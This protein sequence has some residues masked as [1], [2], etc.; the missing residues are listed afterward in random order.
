M[1]L[2]V[3]CGAL[4]FQTLIANHSPILVNPVTILLSLIDLVSRHI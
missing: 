1:F 2:S 4:D 3:Q